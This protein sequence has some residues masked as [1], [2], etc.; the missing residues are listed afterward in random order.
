M[1]RLKMTGQWYTLCAPYGVTYFMILERVYGVNR[2]VI[3]CAI[4]LRDPSELAYSLGCVLSE[5]VHSLRMLFKL[6]IT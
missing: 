4:T 6:S 3:A 2:I 5:P 1:V